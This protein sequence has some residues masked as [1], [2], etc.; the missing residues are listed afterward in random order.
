MGGEDRERYPLRGP[1]QLAHDL[2]RP[3]LPTPE[4]EMPDL[5]TA[6]FFSILAAG[7]FVGVVVGL[8]GMG[9]AP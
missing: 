3:D 6:T 9:A 8:T 1:P 5:I 4:D 2:L 7:F